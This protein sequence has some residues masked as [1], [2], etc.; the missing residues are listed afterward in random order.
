MGPPMPRRSHAPGPLPLA[1]ATLALA[2]LLYP[3]ALLRGEAFFERDLHLDWY[4][5]L[6]ALGRVLAAGA[7]PLW[8]PGLGFGQPLL[9]D[10]SLQALYPP[11]WL[12]LA[13][14]W[15]AAYTS[16][17]LLHL[18]VAALGAARLAARLGAGRVGCWAAGLSFILSGPVQS[19]VNLWTHFAGIA[20]MPWALLAANDAVARPGFGSSLAVAAAL[21]VQLLAGSPD[22]FAVTLA[23]SF[24]LAA[25][26]LARGWRRRA[27]SRQRPSALL[28]GMAL[29]AALTAVLWWPAAEAVSRSARSELPVDVR[30]AWSVP[31]AGLSRLVV[32]LDPARVPFEP[33]VWTRLYDRPVQP[34]LHSL[35]LGLPT[36]GLASLALL[37]P[38]RRARALALAAA[39][40]AILAFAMGPHGP[41]YEPLSALLAP[42]RALR[43]P[44]KAMLA[45]ALGVSLLAGLGVR[46]LAR[47]TARLVLA[48]VL[49]AASAGSALLAAR[50]GAASGW[51]P[52]LGAGFALVLALHGSRLTPAFAAKA[53][54]AIACADL[55]A[56]HRELN[57]TAPAALLTEPPPVVQY[58]RSE[59]G[60]R[61]HVWDYHTLPQ[62]AER[63]LGRRDPYRP[64]AG[65]AG[66]DRRV[67]QFVAQRQV[68]VPLTSGFFG[69]ETS[70]DLDVRGLYPRELNDLT[71]L[72]QRLQGTP[73]QTRLLRMGGVAKLIALHERGFED[74]RLERVVPN[75]VGDPLRVFAVPDPL[76]RAWLVGR[77]RLADGEAAFRALAEPSF[78]PAVMALVAA[79]TPLEAE[80]PAEGSVRWLERRPDRQRLETA[81]PRRA[82]LVVADAYDP[83]WLARLDGVPAPLVRANLAFRGVRV[84][85]GRHLVELV[86]RPRSV[87]HGLFISAAT[88]VATALACVAGR[89]RRTAG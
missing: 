84:P 8:D 56:A 30:V 64:M 85:P 55:L 49:L 87:V 66:L 28:G 52:L 58:L 21:A 9:A 81:S 54:V 22:V 44:S 65:P 1:L 29:A 18:F 80:G 53:L 88:L 2:A 17:V 48:A 7:W 67:L 72:A 63:L 5:R 46:A 59:A 23:L 57:A 12:A 69:I 79:G 31:A 16:F 89:R 20:W 3:G 6:A 36:L 4:P 33:G 32:P 50:F 11:T 38:P 34:L 26:R 47:V 51:S 42:L 24:A 73:A 78:D 76:P 43:F 82:L 70:Y 45:V 60:G 77:T 68:L 35:Y 62:A 41:L 27:R 15:G 86:Y 37:A 75:L 83:G 25:L 13:L 10:P 74:L 40:A 14:P 39:G 71:F 61:V 19:A